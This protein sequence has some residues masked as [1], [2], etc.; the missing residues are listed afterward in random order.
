MD[1]G[2]V[3]IV[4]IVL[5]LG[6]TLALVTRQRMIP[7]SLPSLRAAP[8]DDVEPTPEERAS[9]HRS[10]AAMSNASDTEKPAAVAPRPFL[11]PSRPARFAAQASR[12]VE[13]PRP[14]RV[15]AHDPV[16][17]ARLDR[18]EQ[19]IGEL[20]HLVERQQAEAREAADRLAAA[21]AARAET[22]DARRER[23]LERL[24]ADLLQA[25]VTAGGERPAEGNARRLEVCSDLY[26]RL[27][28]F[29]AALASVTNP[30]LLPGEAYA[31]PAELPAEALNWDNWNEVGERAFALADAYSAQRLYLS[32]KARA[33][34]GGFVTGLRRSLTRGIYPNLQGDIDAAQQA[35]LR[36]ALEEL[37]ITLPAIRDS[38]EREHREKG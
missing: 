26:A 34:M 3:A 11:V 13:L 8:A 19:Q 2:V 7:W 9:D 24:R 23:G 32:P 16:L 12:P 36:A 35:A 38:L 4:V 22:S 14:E 33:E 27:A 29:E 17:E 15:V 21:L 5:L 18:L 10:L 31:P 25:A 20:R 28:R 6:A 1:S 30:I 37:A